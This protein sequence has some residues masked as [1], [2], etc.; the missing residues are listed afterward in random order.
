[1]PTE[2]RTTKM[3]SKID[4]ILAT[5]AQLQREVESLRSKEE[6]EFKEYKKSILVTGDTKPHKETLK[7]YK[8]RWNPTLNGWI[9]SRDNA[10]EAKEEI[11]GGTCPGCH[12]YNNECCCEKCSECD[13]INPEGQRH[14]FCSKD[15]KLALNPP[16]Y[17]D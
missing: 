3:D 14:E 9:L 5:I 1:M 7:K 16:E 12:E 6:V 13:N 15:C 11:L 17:D 10:V 8:G 2:A 4:K